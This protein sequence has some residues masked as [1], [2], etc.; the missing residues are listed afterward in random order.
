MTR[1]SNSKEENE[2]EVLKLLR[3]KRTYKKGIELLLGLYQEQVYWQIRKM[4]NNHEDAA[5]LSQEVWITVFRKIETFKGDSTLYT[6]I[7]RVTIN[8]CLN[9]L[10][11][12]KQ[13]RER[14]VMQN[15]LSE[16]G[17]EG[18]TQIEGQA[19]WNLLQEAV[20][21]L[22]EKQQMVF[23]LRYFEEKKYKEISQQLN[24]SQGAL[25]ASYH[26]AVKKIEAYVK[27]NI[28]V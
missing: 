14:N 7:Y 12:E 20:R 25:K 16:N 22:P 28:P 10:K 26:L 5:D 17:V 23:N 19:I 9:F 1:V 11:K 3:N 2:K 21:L 15:H 6:W 8:K 18:G 13:S 27:E 24:T 4:V